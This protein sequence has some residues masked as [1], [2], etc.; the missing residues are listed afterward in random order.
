MKDLLS[1]KQRII[2]SLLLAAG[3]IM[4]TLSIFMEYYDNKP[5]I[6]EITYTEFLEYVDDG[7][8]DAVYYNINEEY[9]TVAL[10]NNE[11]ENMSIAEREKY[12]YQDKDTRQ[13][14]YPA[15][16]TFREEMLKQ[17][18]RM[19]V[20]NS[21][22]WILDLIPTFISLIIPIIFLIMFMKIMNGQFQNGAPVIVEESDTKF[23]D[24]IG[25]DEIIEDTK[26]IV[27][28]IK[29]KDL[30]SD[31]GAKPPKG[32]LL[33]GPP[34]TGKTLIAKAIAGEA[35]VP[36]LYQNASQFIE[37]FVGMG[38]K[39]VRELFETARKNAPAIIFIDE[40]DAVGQK[41]N[42]PKNNSEADQTI[43]ALLQEMDG[44]TGREGV[45]VIA[46][47][48]RADSLD[49]ALVRSGRFDR[50]IIVNPPKNWKI[51]KDMFNHYLAKFKCDE[52]I[53]TENLSKQL[54]GFTGA[55]IATVC[56]E[57]SIIAMMKHKKAIDM[58]CMEEAIDKKIFK[59]NRSKDQE[60]NDDRKIVAYHEAGHAVMCQC[61]NE[62]IARASIIATVSG[63]GGAVINADKD[64][65]FL[66]ADDL[67][68]RVMIAYAGRASEEIKFKQITTGASNDI[69]QA[70]QILLTYVEKLGFDPTFG[71]L[72][73]EELSRNHLID[74]NN[75]TQKLGDISKQWYEECRTLL[76]E[77][78]D[79]VELLAKALL[80][81]ETMTGDEIETLFT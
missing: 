81:K 23:E 74:G 54:S 10:F 70:T 35:G 36:F 24:I 7:K 25:H 3:L 51:R 68:N 42:N 29:D 13:C 80:E 65:A 52:T 41:R 48:N 63:I 61:L 18:V 45:F 14:L 6:Q 2:F 15:S 62:P 79:K 34:G 58:A 20:V 38:A 32:L 21:K 27:D 59:G 11:T 72:D 26:F 46:A 56:N 64:S 19:V 50:Q 49:E 37:L 17:N 1:K 73:I 43:N 57:A 4:I 76:A 55:D 47:T 22:T 71:L 16:D 39:R 5:D 77:N 60:L 12:E 28:L 75:I 78:Y 66:T 53:N 69:T 8:V 67:K 44:F 30:G 40:L 31:I 9:M 33:V